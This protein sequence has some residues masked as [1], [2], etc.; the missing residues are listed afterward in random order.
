MKKKYNLYY[1]PDKPYEG[2]LEGITD[3]D[4]V[5]HHFYNGSTLTM[6]WNH[7]YDANPYDN[8]L[9]CDASAE[10]DWLD[11]STTSNSI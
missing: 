2:S 4:L 10:L 9:P 11:F 5:N 7:K 8:R 6:M 1:Y 3:G